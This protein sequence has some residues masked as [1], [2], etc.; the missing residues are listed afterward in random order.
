MRSG[1]H[2]KNMGCRDASS[3]LT[4]VTKV[5]D[6]VA[7]GPRAVVFQSKLRMRSAISPAPIIRERPVRASGGASESSRTG[8]SEAAIGLS[9]LFRDPDDPNVK[10]ACGDKIL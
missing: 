1:P 2:H 7:N 5:S 4:V 10:L 9:K 3:R 8:I 6:Q